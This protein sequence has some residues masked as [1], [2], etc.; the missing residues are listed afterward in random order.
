MPDLGAVLETAG[1]PTAD[2]D[3]WRAGEPAPATAFEPARAATCA[4][5]TRGEE[6]LGAPAVPA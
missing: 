5:L 1:L 3:A 4:Y 6:L 2:V